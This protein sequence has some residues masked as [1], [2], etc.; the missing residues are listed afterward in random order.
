MHPTTRSA[1]LLD[2]FTARALDD[3]GSVATEYGLL[4][5]VAATIVAVVLEWATSG[6]ITNLLELVLARVSDL[7][8][9]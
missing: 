7:V 6:G 3:Q 9:L 4:A 8:G 2:R 5:V 1:R